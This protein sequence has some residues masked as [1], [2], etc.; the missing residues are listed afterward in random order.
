MGPGV[1]ATLPPMRMRQAR[2]VCPSFLLVISAFPTRR[3]NNTMRPSV[4]GLGL[5]LVL[6][7]RIAR[8]M[9]HGHTWIDCLDTDRTVVYNRGPEYI[10]G[11]HK[12]NGMCA[13]YMKNY[14]GRGDPDVNNKMTFKI[15]IADVATNARVCSSDAYEYSEWRSRLSVRAGT[16]F[17]MSYTP[18]GHIVKE[19]H[20][21]SQTFYGVYWTGV[22]GT[23]LSSTFDLTADKLLDGQLHNFDDGNCGESYV[24]QAQTMPSQ[25]AGDGFP[26]V[27]TVTMPARTPPGIYH[28]VWFWKFYDAATNASIPT[29]SGTYGGAAYTSCFEVEV[30]A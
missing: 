21:A 24:D 5:C 8:M 12:A 11:G 6:H 2:V 7:A 13:G 18:N 20:V 10:Y 22:P 23:S 27:A 25:R 3:R 9:V 1:A 17:Y 15:L 29:T 19:H 26:C 14:V 28:L 30:T 4:V 16:T